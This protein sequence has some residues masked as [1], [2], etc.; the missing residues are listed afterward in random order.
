MPYTIQ[1]MDCLQHMNNDNE[2]YTLQ[3]A[4]QDFIFPFDLFR[5]RFFSL[6][7]DLQELLCSAVLI[8]VHGGIPL[9]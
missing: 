2:V 9:S 4:N 8:G 6:L 7:F 1:L 5:F 3:V